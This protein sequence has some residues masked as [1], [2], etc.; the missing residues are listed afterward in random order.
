[1]SNSTKAVI[2]KNLR[3]YL[4]I[5]G[6]SQM[7]LANAL[8]AAPSAVTGWLQA[9]SAPRAD[10]VDKICK[11]LNIDKIDLVSEDIEERGKAISKTIPIYN[12]IYSER[13]FFE[14]SNIASYMAVDQSVAADFGIIISSDSMAEAGITFGDVGFFSKNYN[15]REGNIYAVWM[16][17]AESAMLKKVYIRDN[18]Y[19][20]V[21]ANSNMAP[22]VVE[23]NEAFII[24]E[25]I[26]V[27]KK[28]NNEEV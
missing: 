13:N 8:N 3:K 12:S 5:K 1:M 23:N 11:I 24:G 6:M 9:K 10:T 4:D 2:A 21:S 16:I 17:G 27:Y 14:D 22:L 19:I 7:E 26:G 15:F 28:W 25:L 18:K 20:F